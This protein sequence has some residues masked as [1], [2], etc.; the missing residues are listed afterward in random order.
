M[1]LS[2]DYLIL[3]SKR[4]GCWK[5]A[6]ITLRTYGYPIQPHDIWHER[7]C[8]SFFP[9]VWKIFLWQISSSVVC[10]SDTS[11]TAEIIVTSWRNTSFTWSGPV[12]NPDLR[13]G[14]PV[15]IRLIHGT[16]FEG[17]KL[18]LCIHHMQYILGYRSLWCCVCRFFFHFIF[19]IIFPLITSY[20]AITSCC[21]QVSN[22]KSPK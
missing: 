13:C 19:K 5:G 7:N 2:N 21:A 18:M 14:R 4:R 17:T 11:N 8:I 1:F 20:F 3:R 22:Y 15:P 9:D 6:D 12:W 10:L 16:V